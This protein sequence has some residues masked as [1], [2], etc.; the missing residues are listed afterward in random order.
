MSPLNLLLGSSIFS[1]EVEQVF[2]A[3]AKKIAPVGKGLGLNM[4]TSLFFTLYCHC[5]EGMNGF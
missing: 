2:L 5:Y 1:H 3:L 4:N